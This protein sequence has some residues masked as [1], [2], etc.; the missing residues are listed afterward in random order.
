VLDLRQ[1]S[2]ALLGA[3]AIDLAIQALLFTDEL[4]KTRHQ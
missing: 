1:G 4:F 3:G 2:G